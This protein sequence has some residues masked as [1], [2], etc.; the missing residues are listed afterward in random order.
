LKQWDKDQAWLDHQHW[1]EMEFLRHALLSRA[2]REQRLMDSA[3][4]EWQQA[5]KSANGQRQSLT[6]LLT[7]CGQW[8][9]VSEGEDLLWT[10]VDRFPQEKW[11]T[12][13]LA[14]TLLIGGQTRPL[15]RL[16]DLELKRSPDD[17]AAMNNLA[18]VA[19][20]LDAKEVKA[21]DLALQVYQKAPTNS[22]FAATYAFSLYRLG[23][24]SDALKVMKQIKQKDLDVPAIAG[25]YGLILKASGDTAG[26]RAYLDK[27][28]KT[29]L[30]PEEQRLFAQARTGT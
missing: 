11:A 22:A 17:L 8:N 6:M 24:S 23:K 3:K 25:Y 27:A 26:A 15:L 18:S 4:A 19:L 14:E 12:R 20:L 13:A 29:R 30:L 21:N 7:L 9:W 2:L 5:L 28:V 1:R 10:I 16:F